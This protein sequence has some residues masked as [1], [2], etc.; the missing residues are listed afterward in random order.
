MC[1]GV[2]MGPSCALARQDKGERPEV[3]QRSLGWA[4][5]GRAGT[6]AGRW[7][8]ISYWS[9]PARRGSELGGAEPSQL[10]RKRQEWVSVLRSPPPHACP[11]GSQACL[12]PTHTCP[13][14]FGEH[15]SSH[16]RGLEFLG[17]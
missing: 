5:I 4:G 2:P 1:G 7:R 17:P 14:A 16:L 6:H 3:G 11:I 9:V 12:P 15:P 8:Y 10:K 13:S